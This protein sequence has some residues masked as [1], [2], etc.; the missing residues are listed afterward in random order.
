M[1]TGCLTFHNATL[2]ACISAH[3]H[4]S[5]S[6]R[7]TAHYGTASCKSLTHFCRSYLEVQSGG[8]CFPCCPSP[9]NG[10]VAARILDDEKLAEAAQLAR[11]MSVEAVV[12]KMM[13]LPG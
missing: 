4:G 2:T 12:S 3:A 5:N 13:K 10:R 6:S 1:Q 7:I 8:G 11:T 9:P